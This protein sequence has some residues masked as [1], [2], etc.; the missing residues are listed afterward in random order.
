MKTLIIG[1]TGLLAKPLI[2]KMD[3]ANYELR[4]FSRSITPKHFEKPFDIV[5]G[6]LFNEKDL[7]LA[8]KGCDAVHLSASNLD[9]SASMQS[10]LKAAKKEKIKLISYVSG[11]TVSEENRWF[12]MTDQK[13]RAEQSLMNSGIPYLIFRPTWFFDSLSLM[14]RNGRANVIGKQKHPYHWVAASD[15]AKR[16]ITA[17]ENEKAH[18]QTFYIYGPESILMEDAVD[19]YRAVVNPEIKKVSVAPISVLKLMAWLSGNKKLKQVLP[20]FSYFEKVAEPRDT[21]L[22]DKLLGKSTCTLDQ[23]LENKK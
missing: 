8:L 2:Q 23:W 21:G 16:I 17:Y 9:E 15:F 14:V 13:F 1:A 6:D 22:A 5:Q 12:P 20:M 4:L 7:E 19:R 18:N 11:A 3:E 10:L